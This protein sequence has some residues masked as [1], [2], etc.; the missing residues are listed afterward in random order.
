[1]IHAHTTLAFECV[2][3]R[4]EDPTQPD[5]EI[6]GCVDLLLSDLAAYE[7]EAPESQPICDLSAVTAE[8]LPR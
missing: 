7:S 6:H 1:M 5:I 8:V 3:P 2:R 4:A